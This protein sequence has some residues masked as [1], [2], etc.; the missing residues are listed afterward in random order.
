MGIT[1]GG[2]SAFVWV[3][4][5]EWSPRLSLSLSLSKA[6]VACHHFAAVE[7]PV[8]TAQLRQTTEMTYTGIGISQSGSNNA[9]F[10][11]NLL[12]TGITRGDRNDTRGVALYC[13]S[14]VMPLHSRN[15]IE[16]AL[17]EREREREPFVSI[18]IGRHF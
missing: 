2:Y 4:P 14:P 3:A 9:A 6:T 7:L 8:F 10:I 16:R 17:R 12:R 13:K 18:D 5:S 1:E 11:T 15:Y